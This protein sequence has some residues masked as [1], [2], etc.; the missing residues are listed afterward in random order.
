[1]RMF[2]KATGQEFSKEQT[3]RAV[4]LSLSPPS[5]CSPARMVEEI[6]GFTKE[7][8]PQVHRKVTELSEST[9]M[10][11]ADTAES[12]WWQLKRQK[13]APENDQAQRPP[14]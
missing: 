12:I 9:G 4:R 1:M 3:E 2:D 6:A 5:H 11:Y 13:R 10:S 8:I 14:Q 7:T